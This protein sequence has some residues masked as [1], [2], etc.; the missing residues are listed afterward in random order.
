MMIVSIS[1]RREDWLERAGSSNN[2]GDE[3][4]WDT[5]WKVA[6]PAKLNVFL[7]RLA[8]NSIPTEDVRKHRQMSHHDECYMYGA[9]DSWRHSLIECNMA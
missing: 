8:K 6:V 5:L 2:N 9:P 4:S 1:K 3:K 7:W